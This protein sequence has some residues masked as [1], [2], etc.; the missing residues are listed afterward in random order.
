MNYCTNKEVPRKI[1]VI[2]SV[3]ML[4]KLHRKLELVL[5]DMVGLSNVIGYKMLKSWYRK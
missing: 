4:S 2:F 1:T 5:P 3:Y